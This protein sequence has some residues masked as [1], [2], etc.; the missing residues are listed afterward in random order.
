ME[1][2]LNAVVF[3]TNQLMISVLTILHK[4]A[5][6]RARDRHGRIYRHH[7]FS[8]T[9]VTRCIPV[10]FNLLPTA[11]F[12]KAHKS[13][14][15][16]QS[17]RCCHLGQCISMTSRSYHCT[18]PSHV[19]VSHAL[20]A[21]RLVLI[22]DILDQVVFSMRVIE[23]H[24]SSLQSRAAQRLAHPRATRVTSSVCA[25]FHHAVVVALS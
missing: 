5:Q 9:A 18:Q 13:K 3:L 7:S 15:D 24:S 1:S 10:A 20:G 23:L 14:F 2:A 21:R 16:R 25:S 11:S 12:L 19:S 17:I 6:P 4:D 8:T 22:H